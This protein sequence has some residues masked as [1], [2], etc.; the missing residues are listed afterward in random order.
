MKTPSL[1]LLALIAACGGSQ[2]PPPPAPPPPLILPAASAPT[3]GTAVATVDAAAPAPSAAPQLHFTSKP[4]PLPG[5]KGPLSL[6]YLACERKAGRVWIPAAD[7]GSVDVIEVA[8]GKLT[9]I[10]GFPTAE[11][12]AHGKKRVLGPSSASA[13][14]GIVYVGNRGSSEVCAVD[15]AKLVKGACLKLPNP[16][17]GLQYVASAKELWATTPKDNAITILDATVPAKLK[18]KTKITLDGSPEGFVVDDARGV[19][20]TNLEDKD[21]TLAIDTKTHKVTS[22]WEAQCGSDGP[23]GLALDAAKQVLFVACTD[24]VEALDVAHGGALLSKLD[25]GA[26]VDNLDYV[27]GSGL[28]YAA[29]GKAATLTVAKLDDKGVLGAAGT[30]PTSQGAR[31]AVVDANGAVYVADAMQGGILVLSPAP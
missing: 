15:P 10:E 16:P 31:N 9:R 19:F 6:D 28:L 13:G 3:A 18:A 21:K 29:A 26:G 1:T 8:T 12:E 2:N 23:R 24:H 11:R 25:I 4:I 27:D 30:A 5:A 20:Y 7:T 22:T 17:D 14:D